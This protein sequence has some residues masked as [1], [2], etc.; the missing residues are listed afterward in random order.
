MSYPV[1]AQMLYVKAALAGVL[2][3]IVAA[4][5]W[6]IL[7]FVL[8]VAIPLLASRWRAPQGGGVG[9]ASASISSGSILLA[10]LVGFAAGVYWMLKRG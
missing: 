5:L 4:M 2:G 1:G 8:P 10:G 7:T 9:A 6:V 3:A